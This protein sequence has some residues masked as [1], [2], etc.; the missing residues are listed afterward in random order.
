VENSK[1]ALLDRYDLR[2]INI[3]IIALQKTEVDHGLESNMSELLIEIRDKIEN[4]IDEQKK[5]V[6]YDV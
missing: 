5:K 3:L 6:I 4:S 2:N 1:V